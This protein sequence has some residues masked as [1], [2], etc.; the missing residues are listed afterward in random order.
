MNKEKIL[1]I[2]HNP[3]NQTDNMGKTIRNIFS[4]FQTN[5]LCQLYF[6][7]QDVDSQNCNEFF[8][9]DDSS[10]CK[11]IL[12][13]KYKT[14]RQVN[15]N[16]KIENV[17][18][19]QSNIVKCGRKKTGL[20]YCLR[21]FLWKIGKW[22]TK[23]LKE[24]ISD[25]KLS[26][27]FLVAGDYTFPFDIAINICK[28]YNLPLYVY[29]VDEYYRKN[30]GK[31]TLLAKLHKTIYRKKFK[32]LVNYSEQYFCISEA[33]CD[34]YNEQFGKNGIVLMNTTKLTSEERSKEKINKKI[35]IS[36][37]GN[38]DYDRWKN[39]VDIANVIENK[40]LDS[41]IEFNVYS[42]ESNPR[43]IDI[44]NTTKGLNFKGKISSSEVITKIKESDI[45]L[46][47]E[48]F[49]KTNINKVKYSVS[50]KIPDSLASGKLLMAYGPKEVESINYIMRNNAGIIVDNINNIDVVLNNIIKD[51]LNLDLILS[52]AKNLVEK[53][54]RDEIIYKKLSR[55]LKD[56]ELK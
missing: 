18:N 36:Y 16:F 46:H 12:N 6:K 8:C 38:L 7:N 45:L 41:K 30:I 22:N 47:V 35:I 1:I 43:I 4:G 42:A 28:T 24:W 48:N 20:I 53:N 44:L 49:D 29:F 9:I 37:I 31:Q 51:K 32:K 25:Q 34:F 2:S 11:S 50:T 10:I 26:C 21:D 40:K 13:R 15:N 55:Y 33:M 17:T 5:E 39:L 23:Q 54:H 27:V 3:M 14:G 52:N 56:K 19:T